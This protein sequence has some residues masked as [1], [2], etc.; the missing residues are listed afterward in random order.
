MTRVSLEECMLPEQ[1]VLVYSMK[2]KRRLKETLYYPTSYS[3]SEPDILAL[4]QGMLSPLSE[5][6]V[7]RLFRCVLYSRLVLFFSSTETPTPD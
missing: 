3:V 2:W 6:R 4:A 7:C 1:A 5:R